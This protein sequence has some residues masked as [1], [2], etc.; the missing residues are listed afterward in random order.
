MQMDVL[1]TVPGAIAEAEPAVASNEVYDTD[2]RLIFYDDPITGRYRQRFARIFAEPRYTDLRANL[3]YF[4]DLYRGI[5]RERQPLAAFLAEHGAG[6]PAEREELAS[7]Y[8]HYYGYIERQDAAVTADLSTLQRS[9][10]AFAQG[11]GS[12]VAPA[13]R[14]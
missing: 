11:P 14:P 7:F 6:T 4:A 13:A 9:P 12:A 10:A 5:E 8:G 3:N 1:P 2:L